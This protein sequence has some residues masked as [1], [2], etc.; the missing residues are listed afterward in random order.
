MHLSLKG[1]KND[2]AMHDILLQTLTDFITRWANTQS[3]VI[4]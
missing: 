1:Y 2:F 4:G 3:M